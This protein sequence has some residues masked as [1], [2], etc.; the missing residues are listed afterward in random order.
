MMAGRCARCGHPFDEHVLPPVVAD[1]TI[2]A[3]P[4]CKPV[5][6]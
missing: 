1:V 2:W 6:E 3:L 4:I 5:G